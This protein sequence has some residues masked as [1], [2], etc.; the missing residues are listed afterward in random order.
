MDL[1][2][3]ITVIDFTRLLPGPVATHMLAQMGATVI[4]IESPNRKDYLRDGL[5]QI[6]GASVFFHQL[7]HNKQLQSIDYNTPSG[8]QQVKQLIKEADVLI[9]Q[10]RPGAMDHWGLGYEQIKAIHPTII[11]T[12]ISG[13][14]Q[15]SILSAEAG[16]DANYLAY[17]GLLSM[18]KDASGKPNIPAAQIADVCGAYTAINAIQA[19]LINRF[20]TNEGC[21]LDIALCDAVTP[22][23]SLPYGLYRSGLDHRQ[24]NL[25]NGFNAAN[26]TIYQCSD[27]RWL[28]LAA[29]EMK[30][31]NTF[32]ELVERP[33]W[34]RKDVFELMGDNFPKQEVI[35]LFKT[36]TS[37]EWLELFHRKDTCIAP[38]LELE[39]LEEFPYHKQRGTFESFK[40]PGGEPLT[41]IRLPFRVIN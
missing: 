23:L 5:L 38:I 8:L 27:G 14:G 25:F 3:G 2:K 4:K 13:Y 11:Y 30:F 31:W 26:Y 33:Q 36:K 22:L 32:C 1:L 39:E 6:E 29:L 28:T 17:S 20:K 41:T 40:T 10:F 18:F 12:S 15:E 7:N 37:K 9:E 19:A 16:H 34:K 35:D 21:H 24:F